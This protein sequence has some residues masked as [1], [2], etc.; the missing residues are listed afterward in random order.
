MQKLNH[1]PGPLLSAAMDAGCDLVV[2]GGDVMDLG[3]AWSK[4]LGE[5]PA[6]LG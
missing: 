3:T 4:L 2:C 1:V 6:E 5:I